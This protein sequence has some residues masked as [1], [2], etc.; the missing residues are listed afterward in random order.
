MKI[1]AILIENMFDEREFIYPYYRLLEEGYEVHI[2]GTEKETDYTSKVGLIVRSTHSSKEV[3]AKDY[4]GVI[5]P[6]GFSPD[7]MRRSKATVEFVKDMDKENKLI[8]AICHGPW[9]MASCCD[10]KGR[11]VT[12]FFAIKDDLVNAGADYLDEE[13]VVDGNLVTSRTPR[14]LPVFLKKIIEKLNNNWQNIEGLGGRYITPDEIYNVGCDIF[15][16]S[17]MGAIINDFTVEKLKLKSV[18]DSATN[19]LVYIKGTLS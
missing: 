11:K 4:D 13:V 18:V 1:I 2:I 12:S 9:M 17:A 3:S 14:D 6:G 7:Y 5:I 16:P 10:L 19:Q 8:A 15:I